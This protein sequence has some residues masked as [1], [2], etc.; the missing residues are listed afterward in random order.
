MRVF[1]FSSATATMTESAEADRHGDD[2][3][4][5]GVDDRAAEQRILQLVG[6]VGEPHPGELAQA[7]PLRE[8]QHQAGGERQH[9]E[10]RHAEQLRADEDVAPGPVPAP[11]G[12]LLA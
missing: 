3:D 5:Q 8:R 6:E 10:Q 1:S 9:D 11:P 12:G 2:G 7:V 4:E